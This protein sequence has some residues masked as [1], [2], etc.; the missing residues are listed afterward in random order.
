MSFDTFTIS[1]FAFW[2]LILIYTTR[3]NCPGQVLLGSEFC[4]FTSSL[5]WMHSYHKF[6]FLK[7]FTDFLGICKFPIW[8]SVIINI[9]LSSFRCFFFFEKL[10][11]SVSIMFFQAFS[12]PFNAKRS[13]SSILKPLLL[14]IRFL[15]NELNHTLR[16]EK[17]S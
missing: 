13:V 8:Y 17:H 11:F 7:Q 10:T 3:Y 1:Q 15:I 16:I 9:H 2:E 12:R 14:V 6:S 5:V 4:Y